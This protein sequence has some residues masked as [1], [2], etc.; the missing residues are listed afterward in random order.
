MLLVD[1]SI[2][3]S[4]YVCPSL[5]GEKG[6][7]QWA[8]TP[9]ACEKP[10]PALLCLLNRN[11]DRFARFYLF[12]S[13]STCARMKFGKHGKFLTRGKRLRRI[14]EFYDSVIAALPSRG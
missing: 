9:V 5:G 3:V 12:P 10:Y 4:V 7:L 14:E 13:I 1:S 11:N 2:R 6:K 8:L